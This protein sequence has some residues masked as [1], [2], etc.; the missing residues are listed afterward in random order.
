MKKILAFLLIL[1]LLVPGLAAAEQ[2]TRTNEETGFAAVIDDSGSLLDMAEYDRLFA[3][4]MPITETCNVG[5]YTCS[6]GSKDYVGDKAKAWANSVF[7]GTCTLFIIDM[8][9]R[10]LMVWSST[11]VEKTLTQAKAY[12]ITGNVYTYATRGD[13][14]GC[15]ETAF[16]QMNRTLKGG[17]LPG[18]MGLISNI[19]LAVLAA[20]LLAYLFISARMEQEVKVSLPQIATATAGA[21]AVI[22]A[23]KLTRK[24]KHSSSSGGGGGFHGGGGFSSGGGGFG[25]GGGSHG[26]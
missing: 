21:G 10:Q 17:K 14:A 13:Y 24:V 1:I 4:M 9:T 23:K 20:I 16:N 12:I 8:S 3:S 6:D 26:F 15:A 5:L 2:Q 22:A 19:L 25:G 11:D 7:P 18:N